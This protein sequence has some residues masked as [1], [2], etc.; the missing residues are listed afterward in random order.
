MM[1]R[2]VIMT[3]GKTH[4]G[5]TT[6]ARD[7]ERELKNSV[8]ID[9]DNQAEFINTHYNKLQPKKGPNSIKYKLSRCVVDYAIE[10]TDLHLII[11]NSNRN[12][13]ARLNLL[14]DLFNKDQFIRVLVHFD[15]PDD[16]LKKRVI[17]SNRSTNIFRSASTFEEVLMR[18]ITESQLEDVVDPDESEADHLFVIRDNDEAGNIINQIVH[19]SK[20]L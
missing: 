19:L 18:Q 6:F 14:E 15:I 4:S 12:Q 8:V 9:Q 16:L 7:L 10:N 1:K 5:K 2:L 20:C 11:S 13:K 17:Q 3:V